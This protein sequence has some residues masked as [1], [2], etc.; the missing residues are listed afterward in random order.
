MA[1]AP[2]RERAVRTAWR[3]GLVAAGLTSMAIVL[4]V[5]VL[6]LLTGGTARGVRSGSMAPAIPQGA[7][8]LDRPV[9]AA[10]LRV[11]DVVTYGLNVDGRRLLVTHRIVSIDRSVSPELLTVRGDANRVA[12]ASRV[13][14]TAVHG[15]VW[16]TIPWLG[17]LGQRIVAVRWLLLSFL[18]S[19]IGAYLWAATAAR[20][21]RTEAS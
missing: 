11:G 17:G 21:T 12:D 4:L 3:F 13:P 10:D 18:A 8:V 6:P 14:V 9:S 19:G 2:R 1:I 16:L 7:L 15:R 20:R 5:V